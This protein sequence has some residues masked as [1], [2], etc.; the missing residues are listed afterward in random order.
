ME[1]HCYITFQVGKLTKRGETMSENN[2]QI[3]AGDAKAALE[4]LS[5]ANN[6]TMNSMRP[7]LWLI[8]LCSVALG[9]K[10]VA[11][12]IMIENSLWKSIQWGSYIVCCLCIVSWII[13]LRIK[14]ITVKI[15]DINVTKKGIICALLICSLLVLS[16]TIYLQT[17][18]ILFPFLAGI[19]NTSILIYALHV[20]SGA[21]AKEK[22]NE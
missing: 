15:T 20:K 22:N 18:A 7:P 3:T 10:T 16:R 5:A 6:I 1:S 4:S 21:K 13:A 11:M 2:H 8:L 9:I 17:G 12:G 19:L 14:G